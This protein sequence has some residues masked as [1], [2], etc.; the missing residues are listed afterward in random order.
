MQLRTVAAA[1]V[2]SLAASA[3]PA[4]GPPG[5]SPTIPLRKLSRD[6]AETRDFSLGRPVAAQVTADGSAVL[7]LRG[8]PRDTVMRLYQM[9]L[10][11]GRV[12]ELLSPGAVLGDEQESL[13]AEERARRER[14]RMT[15]RGF[16]SFQLSEDD[17]QVL[18]SLGGRAFIVPR[19]GGKARELPGGRGDW[20]D[21]CLSP[22]G[23]YA[24]A[25]RDNELHVVDLASMKEQRLTAGATETLT[26]GVAEFV[27][28]EEMDRHTGF[29]WSPDSNWLVYQETD[30]SQ[31]ETL[32]IMDPGHAESEP[33]KCRYPRPGKP[34]AAV[35]LGVIHR[36]GGE[37]RWLSWKRDQ[38]PYLARVI[39]KDSAPLTLL[40]QARDQREEKIL[41]ADP[42]SGA[43]REL[44][45]ETDEAWLNLHR[46]PL[47]PRWLPDGSAFLWA[48][49]RRG[50]WQLELRDAKGG[51]VRELTPVG[52]HFSDLLDVDAEART[53]VVSGGPD[54]RENHLYRVSFAGGR[55]ER[56]TGEAGM[57]SAT[58]SKNHRLRVHTY[59][60]ANGRAGTDVRDGEGRIVAE[61]PS[62]AEAP[63]SIP[64]LEMARVGDGR[65][66]DAVLIRPSGFQAG[67]KYPVLVSVYGGPSVKMV[68]ANPLA[69]LR[70]QWMADHGYIVVSIDGRG[71]PGYGREWERAIRGGLVDVALED[72]VAA[73]LALGARHPE[74]DLT[75]VGITGWSFGGTFT[76]MAVIRRPDIFHCGVAGAPATDWLD[77]DTHYT[78][79]YLGLPAANP[80]AYR[81]SSVLTYAAQL[82]RPLLLIHGV[83][84][85]NVYFM[86]TLKLAEALFRAGRPYD[87]LP[88]PGTHLMPDVDDAVR[89]WER[90]MD[91]F[92]AHLGLPLRYSG[93]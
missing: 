5:A 83:A 56:L 6:L 76:A 17:S 24:A 39:W 35:R 91:Y 19:A 2:L 40:V 43:T 80:D 57:H 63:A 38:Y 32:Y 46:D 47:M 50:D 29:W 7:F 85:D 3:L 75:R 69:Y 62:V 21:P 42:R 12:E 74:M 20:L 14:M 86:H 89:T 66:F 93:D 45:T 44:L 49:E 23:K 65:T 37:T 9:T 36:T 48:T 15:L 51:L 1:V 13:T 55:P 79:R 4:G 61:V 34:N 16:T 90:T 60:L 72:Q 26:H 78:E 87:L 82:R 73:L 52:F 88:V 8:G 30:L 64:R 25:I 71:T 22:D 28:Q 77:Y 31:V 10:A 53:A 92:N 18:A 81:K 84:D 27:A 41:V 11:N 59:K 70:E 67:R 68:I 33:V 54:S 58:Y